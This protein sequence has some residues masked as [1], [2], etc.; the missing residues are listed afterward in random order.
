MYKYRI[1]ASIL[2]T[3]VVFSI[4]PATAQNQPKGITV[5]GSA[6]VRV[7]P[8]VVLVSIA[9]ETRIKVRPLRHRLT[10]AR[11]MPSS[12]RSQNWA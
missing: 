10:P 8:D 9:M 6:V 2:A 12:T 7:R 11:Q 4:I 3:L 1:V 5:S